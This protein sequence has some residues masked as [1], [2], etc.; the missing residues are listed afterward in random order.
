MQIWLVKPKL[1][2][3]EEG[4]CW[5]S[6]QATSC[7]GSTWG[8]YD[9]LHCNT[10]KKGNDSVPLSRDPPPSSRNIHWDWY[11]QTIRRGIMSSCWT[12]KG[13]RHRIWSVS[14]QKDAGDSKGICGPCP[15][16]FGAWC[17]CRIN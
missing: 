13:R 3:G 2:Q 6:L 17:L 9:S 1:V 7:A 12:A 8:Q 16:L 5:A 4:L 10:V 14:V 15:L 11:M